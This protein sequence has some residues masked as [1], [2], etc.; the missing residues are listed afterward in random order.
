MNSLFLVLLL[1]SF[2]GIIIGLIKPSV[3][4]MKSRKQSLLVFG[5]STV[6]FFILF[7]ITADPVPTTPS[8]PETTVAQQTES[9]KANE[10]KQPASKTA[11]Q[12]VQQPAPQPKTLEEKIT[13]A[14]NSSLGSKTNTDKQRVVSVE[15]TKYDAS[16]ISAYKYKSGETV[17]YPLIKI[18]ADENLTTNLQ[19]NTMHDEAVK[20]AKA[21]FSVDQTIGDII[22]WSQLPVKDQ[23]G[24]VKDDTAI[25]YSMS[26]SLF[27]KVN[28]SNFSYR[29]LPTLLKTEHNIDDRNNYSESIKF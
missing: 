10:T 17:V 24:N 23:Y 2:V 15:I 26:R 22:I 13:D 25:I 20:I 28:W 14:I 27:D 16:M 7:G 9:P 1:L 29:D 3:V 12:T 4:K 6:L 8:K 19:K 21:V 18:N 11:E 5:G